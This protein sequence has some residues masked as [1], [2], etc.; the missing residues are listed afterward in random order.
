MDIAYNR[1]TRDQNSTCDL[2]DA[3]SRS[4]QVLE[5]IMPMNE[6]GSEPFWINDTIEV[7]RVCP[8][9][10]SQ[11]TSGVVTV[12]GRNFRDSDVLVCR[13]TSCTGTSAGPRTC[14]GLASS[15]IAGDRSIEVAATYIST[16]RVG[17]PLP[18]YSF[19]TNGSLL[20]LDGVCEH[21][22]TGNLAYVQSCEVDAIAD[23][24]CEDDAGTGNR[25]VYDTLVSC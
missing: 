24:T 14:G 1:Y 5:K 23:G 16:T 13:F 11:N 15:A 10:G 17:C 6:S 25:F 2:V 22:S 9:Y 20:L 4:H 3:A 7:F 8:E 12:V 21:D 19:P 18:E